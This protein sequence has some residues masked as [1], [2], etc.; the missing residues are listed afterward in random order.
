MMISAQVSVYPLRQDHLSPAIDALNGTLRAS[1]LNPEVG[2]MSTVISGDAEA[3][4]DALR[5]GFREAAASGHVV[6]VVTV[7]NACP[8]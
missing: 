2:A 6:M 4:F 7:S 8:A 5:R 1:G 3:V